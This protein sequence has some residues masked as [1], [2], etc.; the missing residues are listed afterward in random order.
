MGVL[1]WVCLSAYTRTWLMG[2]T[3]LTGAMGASWHARAR[4]RARILGPTPWLELRIGMLG[5]HTQAYTPKH[6]QV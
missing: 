6:A 4:A 1:E 5:I 2:A 3:G